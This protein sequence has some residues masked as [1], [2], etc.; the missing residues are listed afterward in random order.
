[1]N[2]LHLVRWLMPAIMLVIGLGCA[3]GSATTGAP[4][5]ALEMPTAADQ[6]TIFAIAQPSTRPIEIHKTKPASTRPIAKATTPRRKLPATRPTV[7]KPNKP[8]MPVEALA[9]V[10]DGKGKC[11]GVASF[12]AGH[13]L[14]RK[15]ANGE[16]YTGRKLTA[17]HRV[18]PFGTCVRVTNLENG[19][20]VIVR[21]NDRGPFIAGRVIDLSPAAAKKLHMTRQ[22]VVKVK[23]ETVAAW[24]AE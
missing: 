10:W 6:Q 3:S 20:D 24:M 9:E 22:G 2:K 13:F 16:T 23:L 15:T 5:G 18:L 19:L 8:T 21:I 7:A 1:M 11:E 4:E 14:G 12:Y 17:A